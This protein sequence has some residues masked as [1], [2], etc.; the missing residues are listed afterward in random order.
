MFLTQYWAADLPSSQRTFYLG[1]GNSLAS[2]FVAILAPTLGAIADRRHWKKT[3]LFCFAVLGISATVL[4]SP[5]GKGDW[6]LA[7]LLFSLAAFAF[8]AANSF[9]D[10]LLTDVAPREHAHFVSGLGYA[11]GYL[12]GGLLFLLNVAMTLKPEF[13]GLENPLVAVKLSFVSVGVWWAL[14]SLPL[15][16][17]VK[18]RKS[19]PQHPTS[20]LGAF[21]TLQE[22]FRHQTLGIFLLAY[23]FYIDAVNTPVKMAVDYGVALGFSSQS[24][25]LALL[26]V[27]FIAFPSALVFGYLGERIGPKIGIWI[28]LSGYLAVTIWAYFMTTAKEFYL[29]A[30]V[31]GLVQGGVQ[32]LSRS[33]YA[34]LIPKE[35]SSEYFGFFNLVGKFSAILG[36]LLVGSV[37]L[38]T[39]S[40][41]L[42]ILVIPAL[43]LIGGVLLAQVKTDREKSL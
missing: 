20:S 12:G 26:M 10:S 37:S 42:A 5:L 28:G 29:I 43:F 8:A 15:F 21:Q 19:P 36:P 35:R 1:L 25:I 30:A 33:L 18:E 23:I 2:F 40:N 7:I 3:F 41:R 34:G 38:A 11:F 27:Q 22:I 39:G 14:F 16:L 9:Y 13:F 6:K 32:S 17:F 31:I 4:L 24:L